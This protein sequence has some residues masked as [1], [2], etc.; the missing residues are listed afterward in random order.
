MPDVL[1]VDDDPDIRNM[2]AM[3]LGDAGFRVREAA[4]GVAALAALEEKAP[5]LMVLDVMMPNVDGFGV[6]RSRRQKG[7]APSTKVLMV[8]AKTAERDFVRGWE[9]GADEYLTKPFDIDRLVHKV[10]EL[11]QTSA[12]VLQE[13]RE[14]ELQKAELLERLESAFSRPRGPRA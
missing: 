13:R 7:L 14:A 8:T 6:L 10:K 9:L 1:V 11:M 3:I 4:D 5:D 12:S 2:L